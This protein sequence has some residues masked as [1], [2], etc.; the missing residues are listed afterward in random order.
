MVQWVFVFGIGIGLLWQDGVKELMA[1]DNTI[2]G[3]V[4][5]HTHTNSKHTHK[6]IG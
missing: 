5:K 3:L 6:L 4:N 2:K 1:I